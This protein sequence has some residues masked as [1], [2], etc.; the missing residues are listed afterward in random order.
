MIVMFQGRDRERFVNYTDQMF[1]LRADVF[2]NCLQRDVPVNNGWETDEFDDMDPLYI[3]SV[4]DD[5][6][7]G[8]ARLM[9]TTGPTLLK[10][11]LA[12]MFDQSVD[13]ES[14]FIIECTRLA[15]VEGMPEGL[16]RGGVCRTTVDLMIAGCEHFLRA[17]IDLVLRVFDKSMLRIC[18]RIG[19][20]PDIVAWSKDR[21][22]GVGLWDVNEETLN[23][24]RHRHGYP[25]NTVFDTAQLA[26]SR[27][28][29]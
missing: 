27:V 13:I 22:I 7:V 11:H 29:Q 16:T 15:V 17:R 25:A 6:V 23:G 21:R 5:R 28:N 2:F 20:T 26:P 12:S 4:K 24:I 8:C 19:W 1:R 18:H 3:L 10:S 14:P 9:P